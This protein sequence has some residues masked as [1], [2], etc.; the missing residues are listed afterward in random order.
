MRHASFSKLAK[1][2]SE[3]EEQ[4]T[5]KRVLFAENG[6]EPVR[7]ARRAVSDP[8]FDYATVGSSSF[9]EVFKSC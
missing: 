8:V 6:G 4:L 1:E 9:P 3:D 7:P 5:N 2:N